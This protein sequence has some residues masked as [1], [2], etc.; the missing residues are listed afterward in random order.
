MKTIS[1]ERGK[2]PIESMDI[3]IKRFIKRG[4]IVKVI[5]VQSIDE[6]DNIFVK[7]NI[8]VEALLD[9]KIYWMGHAGPGQ[10]RVIRFYKEEKINLAWFINNTWISGFD[11]FPKNMKNINGEWTVEFDKLT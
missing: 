9:E 2:S 11:R 6:N 3:G 4:D 1:F 7:N 10:I 5:D 8:F